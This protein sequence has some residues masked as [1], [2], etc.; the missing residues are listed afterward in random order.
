MVFKEFVDCMVKSGVKEE[1][2]IDELKTTD[3]FCKYSD[4]L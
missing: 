3:L 4:L 1:Q 2:A